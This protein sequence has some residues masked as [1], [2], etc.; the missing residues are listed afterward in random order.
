MVSVHGHEQNLVLLRPAMDVSR[1]AGSFGTTLKGEKCDKKKV[2]D[3][4]PSKV[5]FFLCPLLTGQPLTRMACLNVL[6]G[7][8]WHPNIYKGYP[9]GCGMPLECSGRV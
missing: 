9:T 7:H 1:P 3:Q 6:T 5:D 4:K 2:V 8:H